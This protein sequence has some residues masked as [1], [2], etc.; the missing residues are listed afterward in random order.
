MER[1]GI[2][3]TGKS[4]TQPGSFFVIAV[5]RERLS[6]STSRLPA[7]ESLLLRNRPMI[8]G[9][10]QANED[11]HDGQ[12]CQQLHE[13]EAAEA[14]R[15]AGLQHGCLGVELLGLDDAEFV[16]IIDG[17]LG[18]GIC[19]GGVVGDPRIAGIEIAFDRR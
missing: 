14:G 12:N 15:V 1:I 2:G 18:E 19:R 4:E 6:C 11:R 7:A 13:R 5:C 17:R 8:D 10:A 3:A 16:E 9:T